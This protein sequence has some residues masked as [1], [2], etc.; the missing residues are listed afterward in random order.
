MS[1]FT[2]PGSS[3]FTPQPQS[4]PTG[5][6][7]PNCCAG[8]APFV[9]VCPMCSQQATPTPVSIPTPWIGDPPPGGQWT[10]SGGIAPNANA[11]GP[12]EEIKGNFP[13]GAVADEPSSEVEIATATPESDPEP[14][15]EDALW[16]ELNDNGERRFP[17]GST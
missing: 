10:W 5:W 12:V 6:R 3:T 13:I 11:N 1:Q 8:V 15:A 16:D 17:I 9:A 2:V 14:T 4:A 7:C